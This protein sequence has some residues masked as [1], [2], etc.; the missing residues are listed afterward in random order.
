MMPCHRAES[1]WSG[2]EPGRGVRAMIDKRFYGIAI[3]AVTIV[4][5]GASA[6]PSLLL[7]PAQPEAIAIPAA[8]A[9]IAEPV[10]AR[11]ESKLATPKAVAAPAEPPIARTVQ[12]ALP[13][14]QA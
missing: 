14:P 13:A 4:V 7:R 8:R 5:A 11:A 12:S 2:P 9:A 6:L 10:P 3:A 1:H